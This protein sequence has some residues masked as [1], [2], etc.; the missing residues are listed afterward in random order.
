M[1]AQK[2]GAFIAGVRKERG[3]TQLELARKLQVTDKAVSR[4]ERG[5]GFPDIN[6]IQP[7]AEAL[8]LSILEVMRSQR[9]AEQIIPPDAADAALADTLAL[10]RRK[11]RQVRWWTFALLGT[12]VLGLAV[13][14]FYLYARDMQEQFQIWPSVLLRVL[15]A[16]L[17]LAMVCG[18]AATA[19][20]RGLKE[21]LLPSRKARL[22]CRGAALLLLLGYVFVV[23]NWLFPVLLE[24]NAYY[25]FLFFRVRYLWVAAM[26]VLWGLA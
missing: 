14:F 7:L 2:F 25:L 10:A 24:I 5:L 11:Q 19:L 15:L 21:E 18:L 16:P 3:L 23:L 20:R 26:A 13:L 6:T 9:I 12:A 17:L 8:E 1:D 4:W 22:I